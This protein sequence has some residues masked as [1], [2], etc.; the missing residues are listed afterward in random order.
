MIT[1]IMEHIL[2]MFHCFVRSQSQLIVQVAVPRLHASLRCQNNTFVVTQERSAFHLRL[3]FQDRVTFLHEVLPTD[4]TAI[5]IFSISIQPTHH[6]T[7]NT[8]VFQPFG[9]FF[10]FKIDSSKYGVYIH[11]EFHVGRLS[12]QQQKS[13]EVL[14][15]EQLRTILRLLH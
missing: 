12:H 14:F 5:S 7:S 4:S 10:F 6:G 2:Q 11:G 8:T 9:T 13:D 3:M 15:T 1:L